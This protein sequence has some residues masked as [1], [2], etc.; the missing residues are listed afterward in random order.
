MKSAGERHLAERL[1]RCERDE[2]RDVPAAHRGTLLQEAVPQ[3]A[4]PDRR[5][6]H[7]LAHDAR[8]QQRQEGHG[9]P[10]HQAYPGDHPPAHRCQPHPGRRRRDHQQVQS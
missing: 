6:P 5:A 1:P 8:A 10:H 2:A 4:V 9:C 7:K 3:G